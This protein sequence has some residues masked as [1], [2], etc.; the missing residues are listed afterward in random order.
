MASPVDVKAVP[1]D[2]MAHVIIGV[3]VAVLSIASLS[4]GLRIYTRAYVVRLI[5][6][7]DYLSIL[8][9]PS[10]P[11]EYHSASVSMKH[12]IA[13]HYGK[14]ATD[15]YFL[16]TVNGLGN[17]T[18]DLAPPPDGVLAYSKNFYITVVLYMTA[19]GLIKMTFLVQV[20]S[21]RNDND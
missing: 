4:V 2:N 21:P 17:H 11:P 15:R 3:A 9:L 12:N 19:I 1:H 14:G 6:V 8:A 18:W 5:G 10:S 16:D 7:D 20:S 13:S